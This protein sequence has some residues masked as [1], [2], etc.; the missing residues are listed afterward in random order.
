MVEKV[1][2]L[3]F[4]APKSMLHFSFAPGDEYHPNP[5]STA[6]LGIHYQYGNGKSTSGNQDIGIISLRC[7]KEDLVR[8]ADFVIF[9]T[10]TVNSPTAFFLTYKK[11]QLVRVL[12]GPEVSFNRP[13]NPSTDKKYNTQYYLGNLYVHSI[14]RLKDWTWSITLCGSPPKLEMDLLGNCGCCI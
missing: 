3:N 7:G 12:L 6:L 1:H 10:K 14:I 8:S 13:E 4:L 11:Q 5:F 2:D 9:A